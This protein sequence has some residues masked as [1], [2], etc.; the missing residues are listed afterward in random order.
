MLAALPSELYRPP[1]NC[2]IALAVSSLLEHFRR[3]TRFRI[4]PCGYV[5]SI[6]KYGYGTSVKGGSLVV[7]LL[8]I[9]AATGLTFTTIFASCPL[10]QVDPGVREVMGI[11]LKDAVVIFDE[12]SGVE[13]P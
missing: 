12:V 6:T 13:M 10:A 11:N 3:P 5:G 2:A 8:D 4:N 1:A 9:S 7:F